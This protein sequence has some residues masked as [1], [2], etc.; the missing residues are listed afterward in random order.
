M[1]H[2]YGYCIPYEPTTGRDII[3]LNLVQVD[4]TQ[5]QFPSQRTETYDGIII[6][7]KTHES[8]LMFYCGFMY[9]S[10]Y[11]EILFTMKIHNLEFFA[12]S[13]HELQPF[14][15]LNNNIGFVH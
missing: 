8:Q 2:P 7:A 6:S 11:S 14:Y 1:D 15:I 10:T 4:L 12:I 13:I 9:I 3:K 5:F